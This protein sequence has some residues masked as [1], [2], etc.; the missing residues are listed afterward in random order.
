MN[1]I[2]RK[3]FGTSVP[4]CLYTVLGRS[5]SENETCGLA[6]VMEGNIVMMILMHVNI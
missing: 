5:N 4:Q 2:L 3:L 1:I 6:K